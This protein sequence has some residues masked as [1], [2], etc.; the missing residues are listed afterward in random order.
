MQP[1]TTLPKEAKVK[2][3][4][5]LM[6]QTGTNAPIAK[7]LHNTIGNII[8]TRESIGTYKGTLANAFPTDKTVIPPFGSTNTAV[9]IIGQ[10]GTTLHNYQIMTTTEDT[11]YI[12]TYSDNN[13]T[14]EEWSNTFLG[15]PL[16]IE[17]NVYS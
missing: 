14:P 13:A 5:A 4:V 8:W 6:I 17:I 2:K 16:Y 10:D 9:I 7:I 12:Y 3:Y 1:D 15:G 11:V